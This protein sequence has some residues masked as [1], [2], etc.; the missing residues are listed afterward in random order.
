MEFLSLLLY[1]GCR[2]CVLFAF[3]FNLSN[4]VENKFG[5]FLFYVVTF[6]LYIAGA[7]IQSVE[8]D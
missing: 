7:V 3:I 2:A 6:A 8:L 4:K 5:W 1:M